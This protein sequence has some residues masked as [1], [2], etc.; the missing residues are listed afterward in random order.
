MKLTEDELNCKNVKRILD[1]IYVWR[2]LKSEDRR[3]INK[4]NRPS[5]YLEVIEKDY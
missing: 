3:I 1:K 5:N 4:S 2:M